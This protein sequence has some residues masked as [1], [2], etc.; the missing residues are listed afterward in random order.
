MDIN[1]KKISNIL[2]VFMGICIFLLSYAH[3]SLN[4]DLSITGEAIVRADSDIRIINSERDVVENGAY[5]V[6]NSK[7]SVNT[8]THFFNLPNC[9]STITYK[10][11]IQNNTNEVYLIRDIIMEN[12][13]SDNIEYTID[14]SLVSDN[15]IPSNTTV[16]ILITFKYK[17]CPYETLDNITIILNYDIVKARGYIIE[18][19]KSVTANSKF[20][21][22]DLINTQ[23]NSISFLGHRNI[24]EDVIGS[25]DVTD[26]SK[27]GDYVKLWYYKA[28]LYTDENPLYDVYI[29]TSDQVFLTNGQRFFAHLR[30]IKEI[31]FKDENGINRFNTSEV[32]NMNSMFANELNLTSLD[33][34]DFDTSNVTNMSNMFSGMIKLNNINLSSFDTSKVTTMTNMFYECKL[35]T[36]LDL[37]SFDTSNVINMT[38]MFHGCISLPSLDLSGFNTSKVTNMTS[39]FNSCAVLENLDLSNFNTSNVTNMQYMFYGMSKLKSINL[40]SFDTSN[41]ITMSNMF[42]G[43][44]ALPSLD[45]SSFDTSKVTNMSCMFRHLSKVETVILS[46]SFITSKVTTMS[47]MFQNN[48]NLIELDLSNFNT[49]EVTDMTNM[50]SGCT[51]LKTIYASDNFITTKVTSSVSMF[52]NSPNIVGGAGT[53]YNSSYLDKTYARIDEGE[54]N[55]GYFTKK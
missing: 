55:P 37:S 46:E 8:T 36:S 25:F 30:N 50:L 48:K 32:I 15:R 12:A 17:T 42:N 41:V 44:G 14:N 27:D 45:L 52:I 19:I 40:S 16:D 26:N 54:T 6:Y 13:S 39:M 1:I 33:L 38:S 9:D 2:C 7:Y 35:L 31:N 4:Q 51:K 29:G 21:G 49:S 53:K 23:I 5:E 22:T 10:V 3:A 34:S 24:P 11:T 18:N 20:L 47:F 43:N 28:D